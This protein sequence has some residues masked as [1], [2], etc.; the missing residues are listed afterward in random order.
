M[1]GV[2]PLDTKSPFEAEGLV[3]EF[4]LPQEMKLSRKKAGNLV[5]PMILLEWRHAENHALPGM[6]GE[7]NP[8]AFPPHT[9]S[10]TIQSPAHLQC[11]SRPGSDVY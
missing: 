9:V 4:F 5:R 7:P 10:S 11:M 2:S 8:S 1:P 6:S 3:Y